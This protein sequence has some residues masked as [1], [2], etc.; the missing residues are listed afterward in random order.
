L[1]LV[2]QAVSF[3]IQNYPDGPDKVLGFVT[4]DLILGLEWDHIY[5]AEYFIFI[6]LLLGASLAACSFTR[7]L[8][9]VKVTPVAPL[10]PYTPSSV[11]FISPRNTE[12]QAS[13]ISLLHRSPANGTLPP[14]LRLSGGWDSIT[15]RYPLRGSPTSDTAWSAVDIR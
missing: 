12:S 9:V 5:T 1:S 14:V 8:P 6:N 13:T 10:T 3:Y 11:S 15:R 2:S 7:Q 4:Y